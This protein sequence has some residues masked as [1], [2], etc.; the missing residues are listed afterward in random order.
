MKI[1]LPKKWKDFKI[2]ET[3]NGHFTGQITADIPY[4]FT[5]SDRKKLAKITKKVLEKALG[6]PIQKYSFGVHVAYAKSS[7]A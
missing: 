3:S 2:V 1:R 6:Y 4:N 7:G 5:E